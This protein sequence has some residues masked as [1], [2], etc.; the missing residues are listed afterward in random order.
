MLADLN[1]ITPVRER[2]SI[3]ALNKRRKD[4]RRVQKVEPSPSTPKPARRR[5]QGEPVAGISRYA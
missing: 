5:A 3:R 4:H 2:Q 1:F